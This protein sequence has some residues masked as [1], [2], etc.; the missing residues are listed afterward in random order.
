MTTVTLDASASAAWVLPDE[1]H[2]AADL[3]YEQGLEGSIRFQAPALWA[4]ESGNL[5]R[6]AQRRGRLTKA[7]VR[8]A[9]VT[10]DKIGIRLESAPDAERMQSILTLASAR[11]LT[12]YDASYLEQAL[13]TGSRL[14]S[15]DASL[16]RAAAAE[17]VECLHV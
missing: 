13:R 14:A 12:F 3:L 15:G 4:W 7:Q 2:P 5:L 6:M 9:I 11:S 8:E 16:R 17:G 10:L 1:A